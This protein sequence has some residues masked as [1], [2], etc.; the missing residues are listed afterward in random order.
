MPDHSFLPSLPPIMGY[1][2]ES[3]GEFEINK[4]L[5]PKTK[6]LLDAYVIKE[7]SAWTYDSQSKQN[8]HFLVY[9][10]DFHG[11]ED[12]ENTLSR[13]VKTILE[14]HGYIV[15]GEFYWTCPEEG[16]RGQ[17]VIDNNIISIYE[18]QE[19]YVLRTMYETSEPRYFTDCKGDDPDCDCNIMANDIVT[20]FTDHASLAWED[21]DLGKARE[22]LVA[23]IKNVFHRS[24][25]YD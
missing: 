7:G 8:R 15:N 19:A 14:P 16:E 20:R 13:I 4:P 24:R 3:D 9:Q 17:I 18:G 6:A 5:D 2:I 12:F 11:I 22:C 10:E 1:S 21:G 25:R 23:D